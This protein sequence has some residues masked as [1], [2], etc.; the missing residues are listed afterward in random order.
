M[1]T[2]NTY[3]IEVLFNMT[4]N[5]IDYCANCLY[6]NTSESLMDKYGRGCG[7][8]TLGCGDDYGITFCSHTCMEFE[9]MKENK[10]V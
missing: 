7:H 4:D 6:W 10:D 8:C 9:L 5:R 2:L 1:I 3:G